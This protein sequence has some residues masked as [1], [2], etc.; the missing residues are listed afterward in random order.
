MER[1]G[2]SPEA[3]LGG[4]TLFLVGRLHGLTRRR[5][6]QLVRAR[7]GKLALRPTPKVTLI[8]FGNSA[9]AI[10][11]PDG[12][13]RLPTGL[14][15]GLP[16]I[17]ERELRRRLGLF[18]PPEQAERS[19]TMADM[20]RIAG[21]SRAQLS[22][23]ALFDVIEPVD[24]RYS[25]RDL[26][27]AREAGRLLSR[28]IGFRQIVEA[29]TALRRRGNGLAEARLTEGASGA[30]VR[31]L[32][33]QIAELSGQLTMRLEDAPSVDELVAA[34]E[35]AEE[36]GD[37][38]NAES[39]YA[40]ALRADPSDPVLPFNLGNIYDRQGRTAE[41]KIA[42]QIAVAR[43]PALAEAWYNLAIAAEDEEQVELAVA[44]YRRAVRA[45]PDY[46]D[47]QF[48][49]A[50]LLTKLDRCAEALPIW[51]RFLTLSPDPR[52]AA[53]ARRAA[54]LCRMHIQKAQ[55]RAG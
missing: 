47:A 54:S 40:T 21:L 46:S 22:S 49:L 13:L 27:A 7:G 39:L 35:V 30:L 25:Y 45:Q 2:E 3:G 10:A 52:Q 31:E 34:A 8:A 29:A 33:G 24:E 11:L 12:R 50:L 5:L 1:Q 28:G 36:E 48:N 44:E 15:P 19:H 55:A 41:A 18:A 6:E 26:V 16:L 20:E 43:D 37:L 9:A 23:L 14:P 51:E 17:G 32:G 42:W 4:H 38:A 53:T